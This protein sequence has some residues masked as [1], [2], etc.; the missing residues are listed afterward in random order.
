MIC[1]NCQKE[2][3]L[4]LDYPNVYVHV[5]DWQCQ[6]YMFAEPI[7]EYVNRHLD[8]AAILAEMEARHP[9]PPPYRA[10]KPNPD[11][12]EGTFEGDL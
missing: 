10:H 4:H 7:M 1:K 11:Y 9:T 6:C 8:A 5:F 2:I 3:R 12:V